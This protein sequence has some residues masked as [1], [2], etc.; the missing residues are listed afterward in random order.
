M[1]PNVT[2]IA[3]REPQLLYFN[4]NDVFLNPVLDL[5]VTTAA[6]DDGL[7]L[8]TKLPRKLRKFEALKLLVTAS[9]AIPEMNGPWPV[10]ERR[11]SKSN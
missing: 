10:L 2:A 8:G 7:R 9:S 1:A 5:V 3:E 6:D 4:V 11:K